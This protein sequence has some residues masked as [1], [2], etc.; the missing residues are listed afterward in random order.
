MLVWVLLLVVW[1]GEVMDGTPVDTFPTPE[2]CLAAK[3]N[4]PAPP[5]SMQL[6]CWPDRQEAKPV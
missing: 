6:L 1:T 5:P 2:Q 3:A 4:A